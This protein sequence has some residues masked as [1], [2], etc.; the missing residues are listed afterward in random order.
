MEQQN[1]MYSIKHKLTSFILGAL[2]GGV[3]AVVLSLIFA[4][5]FTYT[6]ISDSFIDV[7]SYVI[8][9]VSSFVCGF[10]SVM[11]LKTAGLIN[12]LISGICFFALYAI[13]SLIFGSASLICASKLIMLAICLIIG[14]TGGIFAVNIR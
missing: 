2:G 11:R 7:V 10:V 8:F 9:A 6:S 14:T 5:I 1:D 13:L 12:G 3:C 4:L